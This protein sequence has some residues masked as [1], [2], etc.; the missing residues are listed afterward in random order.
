MLLILLAK[1][2]IRIIKGRVLQTS[3]HSACG[4]GFFELVQ[5]PFHKHFGNVCKCGHFVSLTTPSLFRSILH[6]ACWPFISWRFWKHKQ[7]FAPFCTLCLVNCLHCARGCK[8]APPLCTCEFRNCCSDV[9]CPCVLLSMR[10]N[11]MYWLLLTLTSLISGLRLMKVMWQF[12]EMTLLCDCNF[13]AWV[14]ILCARW[15]FCF[16]VYNVNVQ[17]S[18]Y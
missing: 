14:Q 10:H 12:G 1:A 17:L 8:S 9:Q 18:A 15:G 2:L 11:E 16:S 5:P 3:I 7:E 6:C 13:Y 4:I